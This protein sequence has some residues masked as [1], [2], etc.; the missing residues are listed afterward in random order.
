MLLFPPFFSMREGVLFIASRATADIAYQ[1]SII[2]F[3]IF[4]PSK[5][6]SADK[7]RQ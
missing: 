3:A 2:N 5:S 6:V 7:E 1:L 4:L